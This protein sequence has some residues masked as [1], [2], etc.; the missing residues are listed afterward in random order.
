[1]S[2]DNIEDEYEEELTSIKAIDLLGWLNE[3]EDRFK[4]A[5]FFKTVKRTFGIES[6]DDIG[7]ES[8]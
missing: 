6:K 7:S 5:Y 1:M 4:F 3:I 8:A 2:H